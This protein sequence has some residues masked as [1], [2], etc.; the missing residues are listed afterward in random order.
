MSGGSRSDASDL[1]RRLLEERGIHRFAT[2]LT[3]QE[4]KPL[5]GGIEAISGFVLTDRGEVYG[6]WLDWDAR[7]ESFVLDPWYRVED[8]SQF[9]DDPE[10]HRAKR[11][12][13]L[14]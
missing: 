5:P 12:L 2:F 11:E 3:Q 13:G 1:L 10:Y 9:A 7:Q 8:P 6:F 14:S 4:G